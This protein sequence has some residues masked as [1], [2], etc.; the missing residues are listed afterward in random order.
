MGKVNVNFDGE[1]LLADVLR[2]FEFEGSKYAI[3]GKNEVDESDYIKLYFTKYN[4]NKLDKIEDEQ[5]WAKLK[6]LIK[7]IVKEAKAGDVKVVLDLDE[8]ILDDVVVE[9]SKLFKLSSKIAELLSENKNVVEQEEEKQEG[10]MPSF[11]L[12]NSD[13]SEA[14]PSFEL[15]K[16]EEQEEVP[17]FGLPKEEEQ[18]EVPSFEL[19][20]EEEQ[21]E[22]PSFE[23]PKE[24]EQEEAPSFELPKEEEQEEVPSTEPEKQEEGE[25]LYVAS[26]NKKINTLEELLGKTEVNVEPEVEEKE[27]SD[28][29]VAQNVDESDKDKKIME[30]EEK[31]KQQE[32]IINQ[33]K[34]LLN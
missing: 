10:E 26:I 18:E 29:P 20:K 7:E 4:E 3:L 25:N 30:L 13:E 21:E 12:P 5:E 27:E 17:S 32:E 8:T 6:G 15:P 28:E 33:I 16:E 31:I 14:M 19:P 2:F 23:V 34:S 24:E 11:E 22:V 1:K 9:G